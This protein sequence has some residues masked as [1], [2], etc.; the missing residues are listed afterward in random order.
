MASRSKTW[1]G[2]EFLHALEGFMDEGRLTRGRSYAAE[3]RR[4]RFQMKAGVIEATMVGNINPYFGVYKTP[5]YKV[6]IEFERIAASAWKKIVK[7]LGADA[8]WVTHLLLGE[9]PPT[10]EEALA[11]SRV[12]LL[13]RS[14]KDIDSSCSCP[15]WANPCKHVAGVYCYVASLLDRDPLLLFEI[16][17]MERSKLMEGLA[18]SEFGTALRGELDDDG[19]DLEAA[20]RE[21]RFAR[22]E[23]AESEA[24]AS[25]LRAFWR[26]TPLPRDVLRERPP[27]LVSALL[28]R[29][30][31]D[32]P[33]FWLRQNSFL[34]AMSG[35]YERVAKRF[36][37]PFALRAPGTGRQ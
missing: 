23:E 5:Y 37:A 25:D 16:R 28:L 21:P 12:K 27:P 29:R 19:P 31:G 30:E 34:E 18:A 32:Y 14:G 6:K 7:R 10:I 9:V 26:G 22:V 35:I 13:P 4:K 1:W 15:D 36:P 11:D 24:S 3:H 8:D 17:G 20:F 2:E 33:E